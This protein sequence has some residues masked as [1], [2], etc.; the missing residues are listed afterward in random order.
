MDFKK[1]IVNKVK[2]NFDV[3]IYIGIISTILWF[4][5]SLATFY[6]GSSVFGITLLIFGV[7]N[8]FFLYEKIK[9][10]TLIEKEKLQTNKELISKEEAE[11]IKEKEDLLSIQFFQKEK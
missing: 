9:G 8:S 6:F 4:L 10:Y 1:K 7:I 11:K 2:I 5:S 3:D